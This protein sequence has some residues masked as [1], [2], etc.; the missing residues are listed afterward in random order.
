MLNIPSILNKPEFYDAP[1]NYKWETKSTN[2]FS[3]EAHNDKIGRA[4]WSLNQKATF[5]LATALCEWIYWRLSKHIHRPKINDALEAHWA[6]I[7]HQD[8]FFDWE[9]EEEF[10]TDIVEGPIWVML[11]CIGYVRENYFSGHFFINYKVPNLVM[12]ARHISPDRK[13]FDTWYNGILSKAAELFPPGYDYAEIFRKMDKYDGDVY[14]SSNE[15]PIPRQ[16]FWDEEYDYETANNIKTINDFLSN[17]KYVE[18]QF[19]NPPD[20][21]IE[22]GFQGIPYKYRLK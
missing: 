21:M 4:L 9:S 6:G 18:N 1:L 2:F 13:F 22:E 15:P 5:G 17:L 12:L 14:E 3:L 11:R 16:F 19:L 8:Y 7:I 20:L 10:T